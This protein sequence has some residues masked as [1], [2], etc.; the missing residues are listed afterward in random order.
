VPIRGKTF[1][2]LVLIQD[3]DRSNSSRAGES[4]GT[5]YILGLSPRSLSDLQR[6]LSGVDNQITHKPLAASVASGGYSEVPLNDKKHHVSSTHEPLM[7]LGNETS[8]SEY[9]PEMVESQQHEDVSFL[10]GNLQTGGCQPLIPVEEFTGKC[11]S[12]W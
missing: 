9:V 3:V 6:P 11:L 8:S 10:S 12:F 4:A 2:L 1:P 5:S 7:V